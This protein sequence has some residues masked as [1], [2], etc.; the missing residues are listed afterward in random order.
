MRL[1]LGM[2]WWMDVGGCSPHYWPASKKKEKRW[3]SQIEEVD[4]WHLETRYLL[5]TWFRKCG[6]ILLE[7]VAVCQAK[8][9]KQGYIKGCF[10]DLCSLAQKGRKNNNVRKTSVV[11]DM[12]RIPQLMHHF[13][14]CQSY[15]PITYCVPTPFSSVLHVWFRRLITNLEESRPSEKWKIVSPKRLEINPHPEIPKGEETI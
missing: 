14:V 8:R 13:T 1:Q 2:H 11:S 3:C 6:Q 12:P 15:R 10:T 7:W 9:T 4:V 5:F